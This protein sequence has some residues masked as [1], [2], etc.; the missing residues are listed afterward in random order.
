MCCV[1]MVLALYGQAQNHAHTV[2]TAVDSVNRKSIPQEEHAQLGDTHIT[3][4]YSAPAVCERIIWGL[5][6]FHCLSQQEPE[7]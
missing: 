4:L 7:I 2:S 1:L 5:G 3:I 6:S